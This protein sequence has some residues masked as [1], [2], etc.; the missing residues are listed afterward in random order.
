MKR[1]LLTA[2]ALLGAATVSVSRAEYIIVI[3]NVGQS[4]PASGGAMGQ[5][6]AGGLA[7][8]MGAPGIGGAAGAPG[9]AGAAGAAG[10]AGAGGAPGIAGAAGVAGLMGAKGAAGLMGAAGLQ[11]NVGAAGLMGAA[12]NVG[13]AGVMGGGVG[14]AGGLGA[15]GLM[16]VPMDAPGGAFGGALGNPNT[17][18]EKGPAPI[19]AMAII[20]TRNPVRLQAYGKRSEK[21]RGH[22]IPIIYTH[23]AWGESYL[24]GF[25]DIEMDVLR[26]GNG[27]RALPPVSQRFE[28]AKK[29]LTAK[30]KK[31]TAQDY[32]N[33]AE[34]ALTHGL[35][36][37][38]E[39]TMQEFAE[40]EKAHPSADAFLKIKAALADRMP[41]SE[42]SARWKNTLLRAF[43]PAS[44]EYY[45]LWHKSRE[46]SQEVVSRL[47]QLKENFVAF[48]YWHALK[49]K[50]LPLPK[51]KMVC[52][53]AQ[54][55]D[56]SDSFGKLLGVFEGVTVTADSFYS[57]RYN[58]VVF[59]S[60]RNDR[61]YKGLTKASDSLWTIF[62]RDAILRKGAGIPPKEK[63]K[64]TAEHL[65]LAQTYSLL[66][67][68]LD[69]DCE[70]ASVSHSGTRQILVASGRIPGTVELPQWMQ[71]GV[72]S[73]MQTPYG[74][75]WRG[76]GAPH[77]SY[78]LSYQELKKDN[79][80]PSSAELLRSVISDR[81]FT[82]GNKKEPSVKARSTAWA[83][84]YFL[85][86]KRLDGLHAYFKEVSR[87]PRDLPLDGDALLDCFAR[88]LGCVDGTNKR[89][90]QKLSALAD[91]WISFMEDEVKLDPEAADILKSIHRLQNEL[92]EDTKPGT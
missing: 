75:P 53:L 51:E 82:E 24:W 63:G 36:A 21:S 71:A 17:T 57:P 78:L 1:I 90:D 55:D 16:G 62:D 69:E 31:P 29:N 38:F 23:H 13:L 44:N 35:I 27:K 86:Q 74:S 20:E 73:F 28:D 81:F 45:H 40:A 88:A 12:G 19:R 37:D 2:V 3:A 26:T 89:D 42:A 49:G 15:M 7:G 64:V 59:S 14:N 18:P 22:D 60:R 70:R 52:A 92:A 32:L 9:I 4:K 30:G 58:L 39:K 6:G 67:H 80:L 72:G 41:V 48:Y 11:G 43:K 84:T 5:A 66:I 25:G 47:K 91:A 33:L 46:D 77:W 83:L 8:A 10:L 85:A 34:W 76:Y 79:K 65:Y 56:P 54:P 50:V 68:A 87:L 61:P